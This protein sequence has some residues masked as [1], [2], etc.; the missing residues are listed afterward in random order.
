MKKILFT[1]VLSSFLSGCSLFH[2]RHMEI[3][4]GN[5]YTPEMVNQLHTGM[6]EVDVKYVM[7][8]PVLINTFS[9]NRV[10]YVYTL[11]QAGS[12][13]VQ[14]SVTLTFVN[15]TLRSINKSY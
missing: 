13:K 12:L 2:I 8:S 5:I 7:G 4:Q 6:T 15:G 1:L 10:D 3:E 11:K 14:K 9:D